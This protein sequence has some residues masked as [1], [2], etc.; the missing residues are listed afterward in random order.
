MLT[1]LILD[2]T[3]LEDMKILAD[4]DQMKQVVAG[5]R[6]VR[7]K[8]NIAKKETL[9]VEII[10]DNPLPS[11]D[12]VV[13]KMANLSDMT[14]I[15]SKSNGASTFLVGTTE[16]AVILGDLIDK[17][18]EIQKIQAEIKHLEGFLMGVEKKLSNE[19][20]VANAP[21]KVVEL[22]RKKQHDALTKLASLTE[23]L[24]SLM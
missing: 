18:A 8:K 5:V 19:K 6:N 17:D 20:F 3:T 9:K 15:S 23:S 1:T 4:M 2:K 24:D 16:Y 22:E 12:C 14:V 13:K 11:L 7:N 10:G 21:Q